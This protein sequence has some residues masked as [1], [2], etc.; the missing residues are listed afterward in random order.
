MHA[1]IS[2]LDNVSNESNE[3]IVIFK[4]EQNAWK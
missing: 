3:K 4:C 1:L 2:A